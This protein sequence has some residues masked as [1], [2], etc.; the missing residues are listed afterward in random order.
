M[1]RR[2]SAILKNMG[3]EIIGFDMQNPGNYKSIEGFLNNHVLC[4][5]NYY[6]AAIVCTPT[7]FHI[8]SIN[9]LTFFPTPIL[10]EKP[11]SD[12]VEKI[13]IVGNTIVSMV[14]NWAFV[15]SG[16]ILK[17]NDNE[18]HYNYYNAGSERFS[19]PDPC[20]NFAMNCIQLIYLMREGGKSYLKNTSPFFD[21]KINGER[22]TLEMV[23]QSYERM[24]HYWLHNP[25][26]LWD[27]KDAAAA[28]Q[29]VYDY[30]QFNPKTIN[31]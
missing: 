12:S 25:K 11:I 13:K 2:Y 23:E 3:H 15:L 9:A 21:C 26:I 14:C 27:M 31:F 28:T 8:D 22:V 1:G 29:R 18:I 20:F 19:N 17:F 16:K 24:L 6:T 10:C 5:K 30:V 4:D 7:K